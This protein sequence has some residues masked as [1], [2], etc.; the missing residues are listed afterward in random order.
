MYNDD[1]VTLR[2]VVDVASPTL[3]TFIFAAHNYVC[4]IITSQSQA[5]LHNINFCLFFSVMLKNMEG[6][7]MSLKYSLVQAF[8]Q[9][10]GFSFNL[11]RSRV[12]E[13]VSNSVYC[14]INTQESS[15]DRHMMKM[16]AL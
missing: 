5:G 10:S 4:I 6:L 7:G 13:R 11:M 3:P 2:C 16:S 1:I 12:D 9:V 14:S 8:P 15:K